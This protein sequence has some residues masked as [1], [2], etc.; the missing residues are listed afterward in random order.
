MRDFIRYLLALSVL[1]AGFYGA[2]RHRLSHEASR[3]TQTS[4]SS[5]LISSATPEPTPLV[6]GTSRQPALAA[7]IDNERTVTAEVPWD[8]QAT[9]KTLPGIARRESEE[10]PRLSDRDTK[11]QK[12]VPQRR[13]WKDDDPGRRPSSQAYGRVA[14]ETTGHSKVPP[15]V[16]TYDSVATDRRS[17]SRFATLDEKPESEPNSDDATTRGSSDL[18]MPKLAPRPGSRFAVPQGSG[19]ETAANSWATNDDDRNESYRSAETERSPAWAATT[20]ESSPETNAYP[21]ETDDNDRNESYRSAETERSSAWAAE[22]ETSADP[23]RS[24]S[25]VRRHR[26]AVGDTLPKLAARYL[27]DRDR[28]LEIFHANEQLLCDPR[29]LPIGVEVEIPPRVALTTGSPETTPSPHEEP[30]G[31]EL[32][33]ELF[34]T[35]TNSRDAESDLEPIPP[36]ALPPRNLGTWQYSAR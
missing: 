36:Q 12:P 26:I 7:L 6:P 34:G 18:P 35:A 30:I 22:T 24:E 32:M 14:D 16:G 31:D 9:L 29:L 8:T 27:G 23:N 4:E 11:P 2:S 25:R 3:S 19:P 1:A 15:A 20:E 28:Y 13:R 33:D 5:E 17:G 21:W 10:T